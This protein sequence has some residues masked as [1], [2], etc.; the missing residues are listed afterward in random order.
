[1]KQNL[2]LPHVKYNF[3]YSHLLSSGGEYDYTDILQHFIS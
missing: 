2:H 1:M 3:A